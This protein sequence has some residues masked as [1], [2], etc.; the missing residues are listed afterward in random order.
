MKKINKHIKIAKFVKNTDLNKVRGGR[1][2]INCVCHT[3]ENT[4]CINGSGS[5]V[6][7]R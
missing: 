5:G 4:G 7:M 3:T 1:A 2:P 6:S